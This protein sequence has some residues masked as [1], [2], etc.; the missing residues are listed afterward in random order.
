MGSSILS[1]PCSLFL[2]V[3]SELLVLVEGSTGEWLE[4]WRCPGQTLLKEIKLRK[5]Q[6]TGNMTGAKIV[7]D[8]A[9]STTFMEP[10]E[11]QVELK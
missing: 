3:S 9:N 7:C 8:D 4:P 1:I 10:T 11:E 2:L 5:S 6:M